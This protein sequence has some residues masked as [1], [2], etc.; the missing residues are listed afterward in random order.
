MNEY[1][2]ELD[3]ESQVNTEKLSEEAKKKNYSKIKNKEPIL[4]CKVEN[5]D[6]IS[7]DSCNIK[8][9]VL[10]F[11]IIDVEIMFSRTPF[12]KENTE[13]FSYIKPCHVLDQSIAIDES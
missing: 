12:L 1:D 3:S 10:K 8:A 6:V 9:V 5:G 7:V 13:E 11:Y 2:G 4:E